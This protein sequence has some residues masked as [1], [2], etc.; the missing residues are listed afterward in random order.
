M[1]VETITHCGG[2]GFWQFDLKKSVP[3]CHSARYY[4]RERAV[5][6]LNRLAAK[7]RYLSCWC[8]VALLRPCPGLLEYWLVSGNLRQA[9]EITLGGTPNLLATKRRMNHAWVI[10]Q[11]CRYL[12]M[13]TV[14]I[15]GPDA[16]GNTELATYTVSNGKLDPTPLAKP[17]PAL[18]IVWHFTLLE[19][20]C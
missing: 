12:M 10:L 14:N 5:L 4:R 17:N 8:V 13:F 15:M 20:R 7:T 18:G 9:W 19:K 16:K 1:D 3:Q 11:G 2:V 6:C